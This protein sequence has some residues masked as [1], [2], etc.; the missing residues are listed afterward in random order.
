MQAII[1][2]LKKLQDPRNKGEDAFMT[3]IS[4]EIRHG[5]GRSS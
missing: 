1:L 2:Q 5:K 4:S 3:D